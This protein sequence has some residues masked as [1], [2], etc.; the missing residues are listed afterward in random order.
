MKLLNECENTK[1][2]DIYYRFLDNPHVIGSMMYPTKEDDP[3][4][5]VV[6]ITF[7]HYMEIIT[8]VFNVETEV[9]EVL[10]HTMGET[11]EEDSMEPCGFITVDNLEA[12]LKSIPHISDY[13]ENFVGVLH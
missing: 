1:S 10:L 7:K 13:M 12:L 11:E 2:L 8:V 9:G 3:E 6:E 4:N 5:E